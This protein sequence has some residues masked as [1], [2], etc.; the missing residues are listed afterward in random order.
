[1]FTVKLSR[2]TDGTESHRS[3]ACE[4]YEV[5][6]TNRDSPNEPIVITTYQKLPSGAGVEH[7]VGS[8]RP[9]AYDVCFIENIAGKTIARIP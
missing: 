5:Y 8:D 3:I 2:L 7:H 1:M 6:R 9:D 4:S